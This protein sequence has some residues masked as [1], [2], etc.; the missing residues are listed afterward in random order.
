M[1]MHEALKTLLKNGHAGSLGDCAERIDSWLLDSSIDQSS[2]AEIISLLAAGDTTELRDRFYRDLEFGT[3]GLRG[4]I[5]AGNNRMNRYVVRR[6]AQGLANFIKKEGPD[7]MR[8]GIAIAYDCRN[9]SDVYAQEAAGVMAANGI[10]VHIFPTL[11]TTPCLSFAIRHLGCVSGICVTASHNPPQYNG[12]KV[13]WEDGAQIIAPQDKGILEEV[14]KIISWSVPLFMEFKE[15]LA[16]GLIQFISEDVIASYDAAVK[17]LQIN[18]SLPKNVSIVYTPL[19]GT[20]AT[21][22][23]RTLSQWGYKNLHIVPEQEKP[24]GRFPTVKKPNPEEPEAMALAIALAEKL[25]ADIALATDPDSDRLALVVRDPVAAKG[26]FAHQGFGNYVF[27]NGNQTG[28]LLIDFILT[29]LAHQKLLMPSHKIVKTI[30]TSDLHARICAAHGIEIFNTLTGFK[31]IGG[32]VRSWETAGKTDHVYLFG[33][34]ESFGFMPGAYVRD[35]DGVAALCQAVEMTS[36]LQ[37][38]GKTACSRL[39]ELFEKHGSWHEDLI[40]FDLIGEAGAA[41]IGRIMTAMRTQPPSEFLTTPVKRISDYKTQTSTTF[42]GSASHQEK[43]TLPKSDVLQFELADGSKISMRPSG[44]EP[45]LKIYLSVC[46]PSIPVAEGYAKTVQR[47]IAFRQVLI[48][49]VDTI[50]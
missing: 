21:S 45:K 26:L 37:T 38:Q 11:E 25:Q 3:G 29:E 1:I 19:H 17:A 50:S 16:S 4:V 28:A 12:F 22:V 44:T 2:K 32:L 35:K 30:V 23:R 41:R 33:T 48:E 7:A 10:H 6:A 49:M 20:G 34:E 9:Q 27:L 42:E 47:V 14:F 5:G 8:R 36:F 13:Y 15:G 31:W 24:D 46:T 43:I 39:L 40:S 18:P